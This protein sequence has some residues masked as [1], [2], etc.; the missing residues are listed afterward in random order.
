MNKA[1]VREPDD[2]GKAFCPRCGTLGVAVG[3]GPMDVHIREG[4]RAK[5]REAAW[6][7]PFGRCDVAYFNQLEAVVETHELKSP[8]YPKDF[9]APICACFGFTYDEVEADVR[10]GAPTRIRALLAKSQSADAHCKL[11]AVDGRCC[12]SAVTELYL[13]LQQTGN[14]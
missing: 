6:F 7:C 10:D 12:M 9:D 14:P 2:N 13:K 11:L 3:A 8:V 4:S 5:L 1:F